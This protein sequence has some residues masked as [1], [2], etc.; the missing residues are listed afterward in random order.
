MA[1]AFPGW[2]VVLAP[3]WITDAGTSGSAPLVAAAMAILSA[4]QRSAHQPPVGPANGL[5]YYLERAAP[6]SFWDVVSGNNRYLRGVPGHSAKPGYD[7]AS[8]LGV[9]QFATLAAE[10]P[11]PA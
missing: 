11:P 6:A 7:L 1:S 2:P 3:H 10:L 5:F 4:D 9:P 8:G